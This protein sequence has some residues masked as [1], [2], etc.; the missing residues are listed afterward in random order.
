MPIRAHTR[1]TTSSTGITSKSKTI[2]EIR[3]GIYFST[4]KNIQE[5]NI[6]EKNTE[7]IIGIELK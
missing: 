7:G 5:K 1:R 4:K 2:F 6:Q 3:Y